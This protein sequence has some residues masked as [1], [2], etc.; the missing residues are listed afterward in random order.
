MQDINLYYL[1]SDLDI[2]VMSATLGDWTNAT[3]ST[4]QP[5]NKDS[6]AKLAAYYHGCMLL[7]MPRN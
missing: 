2:A 5:E 4:G 6:G 1:N 7:S 3:T